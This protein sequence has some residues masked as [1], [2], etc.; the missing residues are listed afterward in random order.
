[1]GR[2]RAEAEA[3]ASLEHP[4]IVPIYEVGEHRGFQFFSMR[5]VEGQTLGQALAAGPMPERAA[6]TLLAKLARAVHY[7]HQRGVLHRDLKP[8]NILLDAERQPHL[9]DFGLAKL[10]EKETDLTLSGAVLGTPSY[11][12]PEQ[13]AGK[14]KQMTT[15]ADVYGLGA[16]LFEMLTGRVPFAA[17][18]SAETVRQV[19]DEEPPRPSLL[20]AAVSVAVETICLK[21]L[22]KQPAQRYESALA[23]AE[24][25][26]RWLRHEPIRARPSTVW[27]R[28]AKWVRRQPALA[29]L[30]AALSMALLIGVPALLWQSMARQR[31]LEANRRALYV[32]E[33]NVA[34][35]AWQA[36]QWRRARELLAGAIP[37]QSEPDLRGFE[38][39]YLDTL[40][41]DQSVMTRTLAE[42]NQMVQTVAISP[43]RQRVAAAGAG[44]AIEIWDIAPGQSTNRLKGEDGYRCILFTPDG[45]WL[46]SGGYDPLLR[47]WD[48]ATERLLFTLS[49]HSNYVE[50]I[51]V[52]PDGR[53]V[54]SGSRADGVVKVWDLPARAAAATLGGLP[55]DRPSLAFS[56]DGTVLAWGS[57][58]KSVRLW[59]VSRQQEVAVL[60]GHGGNVV[61]LAASPDGQWLAS[62]DN[63]G[64]VKLWDWAGQREV[65]TL[66]GHRAWV[67]FFAQFQIPRDDMRG[68]HDQALG[69]RHERGNFH[70]AGP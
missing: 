64:A 5:F 70:T 58:D 21:C 61:S 48:V 59:N 16:V 67:P 4:N 35:Q 53:W 54:A 40:C 13:A 11:M 66:H 31:A 9:T 46:L 23:L 14:T 44:R 19:L 7:A 33:M 26:E 47:V 3:A 29:G 12:S 10:L 25:L 63:A 56:A 34:L 38:W 39:H 45:R 20:N 36:G 41:R 49:G 69:C 57:G 6:A 42:P 22:E 55:N 8:N 2:F 37:R 60:R 18:S 1:M 24:D 30:G 62:S 17:P 51:A 65:A 27:E 28:G 52:S 68:W 50:R 15:A 43:D 32:M